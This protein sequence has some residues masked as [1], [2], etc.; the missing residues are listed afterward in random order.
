MMIK[1]VMTTTMTMTT[2]DGEEEVDV[3]FLIMLASWENKEPI[4]KQ[5]TMDFLGG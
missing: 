5:V 1:I 4:Q 2:D 3:I